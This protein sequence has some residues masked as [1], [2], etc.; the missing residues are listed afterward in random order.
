MGVFV[1]YSSVAGT[2]THS[3]A[4]HFVIASSTGW[5]WRDGLFAEKIRHSL[6]VEEIIDLV[7]WFAL[8]RSDSGWSWKKPVCSGGF[9]TFRDRRMPCPRK[10]LAFGSGLALSVHSLSW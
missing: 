1:Q 9:Q 4:V 2:E 3:V 10:A 7:Y 5:D 6:E 8:I